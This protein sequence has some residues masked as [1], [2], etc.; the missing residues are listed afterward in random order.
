ME[1][2]QAKLFLFVVVVWA[3]TAPSTASP[4]PLIYKPVCGADGKVYGNE[5][6]LKASGIKPAES[7]ETCRGHELCPAFCTADYKPVCV[8]GKIYG[9]RCMMQSHYC[10][11]M[12]R[13]D[14][15]ESC[16]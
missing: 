14:P 15:L 4:C 3:V 10:G 5:C 2:L 16:K 1:F 12:M 8:E 6:F 11:K 9:N 13:E 7:W